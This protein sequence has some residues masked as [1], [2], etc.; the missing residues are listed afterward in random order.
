MALAILAVILILLIVFIA[1]NTQNVEISFLG[2]SVQFPLGLAL[3]LAAVCGA[4]VALLAGSMRILQLR[5]QVRRERR[6]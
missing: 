4:V 3:L 2:G 1:Q 6:R 5:R